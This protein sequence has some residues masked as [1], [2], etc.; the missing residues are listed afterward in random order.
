MN[1]GLRNGRGLKRRGSRMYIQGYLPGVSSRGFQ[2]T[3]VSEGTT[4][5]LSTV[6]CE[7]H[8]TTVGSNMLKGI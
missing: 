8:T 7:R 6:L 2:K 5:G 1:E 3:N 4:R